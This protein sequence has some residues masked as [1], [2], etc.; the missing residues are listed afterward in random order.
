MKKPAGFRRRLRR[1]KRSGVRVKAVLNH[2]V[3]GGGHYT[4]CY[5]MLSMHSSSS[6][7]STWLLAAKSGSMA[8]LHA[9]LAAG[10]LI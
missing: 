9:V 4:L 7:T 6:S 2:G 5:I 8:S 10:V 3:R 1:E